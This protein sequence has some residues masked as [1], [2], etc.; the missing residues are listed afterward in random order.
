MIQNN[1][2][3]N[4]RDYDSQTSLVAKTYKL[5]HENQTLKY[6]QH[7]FQNYCLQPQKCKMTIWQAIDKLN[8]IV[9]ESDP[10]LDLPQIYHA[11]QVGEKMRK[12]YHHPKDD[13][14]H[15]IGFIHDLGKVLLLPELGSLP[16]WSVVGDIYPLGCAFSDKIIYHDFF[17]FNPDYCH[18]LY[19]TQFGIYEPHIGLDQVTFS[20][21][22]DIYLYSICQFNQCLIP[23]NEL[24][25]I[26]YHSFYSG[27]EQ[28]AYSYLMNKN[29]LQIMNL[30]YQFS[31]CDLYTKDNNH[32]IDIDELQPYYD[33]LIQKYFPQELI[34]F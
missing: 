18:S 3:L 33:K 5:N 22:H 11:Y 10:D 32:K 8:H 31:Q 19:Q 13:Y 4:Y 24:K 1:K 16:Q 27:F 20:F 29:D 14:M 17:E 12:I 9:D 26:K 21:G 34:Q 28:K 15:L 2:N 30:C 6:A 25:I 7:Q 23:N